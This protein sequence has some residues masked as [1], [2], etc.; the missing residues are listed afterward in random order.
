MGILDKLDIEGEKLNDEK[1]A[2]IFG[3]EE[4][5]YKRNL[6]RWQRLR[7]RIWVLFNEPYS[8]AMAKYIA[9][10]SVFFICLSVFCFCVKNHVASPKN[11]HDYAELKGDYS[12]ITET[13]IGPHRTFFYLEHACN[14]WFTMEIA[15]RCLV[16]SYC[17]CF[18]LIV[19]YILLNIN[20][21]S[22]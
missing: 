19:N 14:A 12:N 5:Y 3:F 18:N 6:T 2:R 11:K 20:F 22:V 13:I 7:S 16:R 9:C 4:K 10:V 1:V 15:L 21:S 8:S 17:T